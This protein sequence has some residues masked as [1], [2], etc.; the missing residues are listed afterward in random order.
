MTM[1]AWQQPDRAAIRLSRII[2]ARPTEHH[3]V[4]SPLVAV[5]QIQH[6]ITL[7]AR[8]LVTGRRINIVSTLVTRRGGFVKMAMHNSVCC[9]VMCPPMAVRR[10]TG[11]MHL[12]LCVQQT[13]PHQRV[14]HV[15]CVKAIHD[16]VVSVI[17][18]FERGCRKRPDA[19]IVLLHCISDFNDS[20]RPRRPAS[21][22]ALSDGM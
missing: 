17:I 10:R 15:D 19:V 22:S 2:L 18:G 9:H 5:E 16:K 20:A 4:A 11:H 7:P 21:H 6:R 12:A 13:A 1:L 14:V 8:S 3:A